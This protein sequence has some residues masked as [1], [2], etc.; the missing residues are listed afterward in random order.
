[1]DL[2]SVDLNLFL[3]FRAIHAQRSVT[4]AGDQLCMTQSAVSYALKRLRERF[5]DPLFVRTPDGMQPTPMAGQLIALVEQGIGS[6]TQAVD[7]ARPFDPTTAERCFRLAINDL[8][9]MVTVP[10]LLALLRRSAPGVALR[11]CPVANSQEVRQL[12]ESGEAEISL[13]SWEPLGTGFRHQRVFDADFCVLMS[14]HHPIASARLTLDDYLAAEH[15]AYRPSGRSDNKL[16][17]ALVREGLLQRRRVVLQAAHALGLAAI[18]AQSQLLLTVPTRLAQAL[19]GRGDDL[20]LAALPFEVEPFP[21]WTQ[22][23][24]RF[25]ADGGHRW[26]RRAMFDLLNGEL[27]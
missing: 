3:V 23:H 8:G 27:G 14:R 13:G 7:R 12:L 4:A 2:L 20:H 17:A 10:R 9:Q 16:H 18:V 26:F 22:W 6:F 25:D 19:A 15:I 1:M 21:I 24:D 5:N 11:T